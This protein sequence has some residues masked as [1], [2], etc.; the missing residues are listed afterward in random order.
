MSTA[1]FS[2]GAPATTKT[3]DLSTKPRRVESID[4]LRGIV[5]IIMA[6]DHARDYF[7]GSA[8]IFDPTDLTKT[9]GFLFFTRW[10]THFCAPVFMLL[11]GV[12]A[13]LYGLKNGR[14]ALSFF[15]MTRGLWLIFVELTIVSIG[16]TF[17]VHFTV[18]I[19]QVIWAF[20][21]SMLVL[22]ALLGLR[23][24]ALLAV[25]LVLIAGHNLLDGIHVAGD[26]GGAIAWAFLHEQHFFSFPPYMLAV[27]YPILPWI[28]LICLGYCLGQLYAPDQDPAR[29]Q[30]TLRI[31]G[32]SAIGL[33]IG[34]RAS[35]LYGDPAPWSVQHNAV[36]TIASFFNVTKY[37]PSLLYVGMTIGPALLFL[38]FTEKP[39]NALTRKLTVFGRVP[40]FY[41]LVHIYLLHAFAV[42]GAALSGHK[43]SDMIG[44]TTWVTG[45]TQLK[46]YGFSLTVVYLVW[47]GTIILLYP[48]CKWFDGYKRANAAQKKWLSYI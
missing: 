13:H 34:L 14:K 31:L 42:I 12:S 6:L 25:A 47:I 41:Y 9:S 28:G 18:Y 27:G 44:L 33:F 32:W 29:R 36:F 45:N 39:L 20:G 10:I 11:S 2:L 7:H 30:K 38:S 35:N 15:L 48:L 46:G 19:V 8:Y 40:M 1:D 23:P 4:L 5:M 16:W 3:P 26:G 43:A 24:K 17:N 22:S 21:V 37:P